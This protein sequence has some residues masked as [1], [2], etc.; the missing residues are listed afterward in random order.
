MGDSFQPLCFILGS[1]AS[2][3]PSP[4]TLM[5]MTVIKWRSPAASIAGAAL[6]ID[7]GC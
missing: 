6:K 7:Q 5:A 3:R 2:R 1:M 4:S